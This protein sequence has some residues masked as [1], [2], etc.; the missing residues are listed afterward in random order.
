MSDGNRTLVLKV[1]S[2]ERA[3]TFPTEKGML[4]S[5]ETNGIRLAPEKIHGLDVHLVGE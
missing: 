4:G 5:L 3:K 2:L 1:A